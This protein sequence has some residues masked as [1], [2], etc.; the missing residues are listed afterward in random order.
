[1][2][3]FTSYTDERNGKLSAICPLGDHIVVL[4]EPLPETSRSGLLL[5]ACRE[6]PNRG[7]VLAVGPGRRRRHGRRVA[8]EVEVGDEVCFDKWAAETARVPGTTDLLILS[9]DKCYLRMRE[10]IEEE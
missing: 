4:R 9:S 10:Y 6:W 8:P 2:K 3:G 1:M 5:T 7:L